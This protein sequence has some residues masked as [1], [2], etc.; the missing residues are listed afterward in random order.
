[1]KLLKPLA[2]YTFYMITN[3]MRKSDKILSTGDYKISWY[4][5]MFQE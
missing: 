1:M 5:N 2:S 3:T 4:K